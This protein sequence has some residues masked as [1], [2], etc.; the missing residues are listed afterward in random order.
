MRVATA[1]LRYT[2]LRQITTLR[3]ACAF[4]TLR[5]ATTTTLRFACVVLTALRACRLSEARRGGNC[6]MYNKMV[7]VVYEP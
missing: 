7:V 1:T 6:K 3:F 4:T 2:A 5:F